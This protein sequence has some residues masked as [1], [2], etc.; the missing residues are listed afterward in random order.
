MDDGSALLIILLLLFLSAFFSGS[1]TAFFSLPRLY[2]KK[3]EKSKSPKAKRIL[4]LLSKPRQLLITIL[5]GNTFVNMG[6]SSLG[7]LLAIGIA[8]KHNFKTSTA[9]TIQVLVT[10]VVIVVFGEII[11]KLI[12]IAT[13][14]KF[15]QITSLPLQFFSY[16]FYGPVWL[17]DKF[18]LLLAKKKN[19]D[20][21]MAEKVTT[22]EIHNL[23]QSESSKHTLDEE[24]KKMLVGLFRF[25]YAKITEIYVPRVKVKA[26]E[27]N[28]SLEELKELIVSTGFSRIPVYRKTIDEIVG[29][30]YVKDLILYPEKKTIKELMRP[31]WFVT[32]NM[33]VQT[34][35]NQFKQKKMQ[36][37]IVVD[38]YGGTSG[39]ISLEDILEE[40]VGEIQ[41]EYDHYEIPE[42]SQIDDNT[43][44]M[45]GIVSI[46]LF[47]EEL[48]V[49]L[50]AEEYD[51]IAEFLLSQFNYVPAPGETF[52][53]E[54]T[55]QFKVLD[56]D[57]KSIKLIEVTK[58][59]QES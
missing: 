19:V 4:K 29:I 23:I 22:E 13:A 37:A 25:K 55:L 58:L 21:H 50:D 49:A 14:N 46:R 26:I 48:N 52:I 56:S 17:I 41:D 2:L 33:K 18:N 6:I 16:L 36:M 51:N 1:E 7:A 54:D 12:A 38:E 27:E 57:D 44:R 10:T 34:L 9:L 45:Q 39:I 35:L 43:Y 11:P 5:L 40:I 59:S 31:A 42:L 15:A 8:Q 28:G 20:R 47:N 24:E 3:L 32:E 53:W 30:I